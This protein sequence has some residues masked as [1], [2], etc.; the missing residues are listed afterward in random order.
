M[1]IVDSDRPRERGTNKKGGGKDWREME[2]RGG[3]RYEME[4][5]GRMYDDGKE[6][7]LETRS[8]R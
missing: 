7:E 4:M 1:T 8:R 2:M 3:G 6:K 5:D